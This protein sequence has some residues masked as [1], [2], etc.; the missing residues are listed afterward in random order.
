VV[1]GATRAPVRDRPAEPGTTMRYKLKT[2]AL[3]ALCAATPL[4][5]A[6]CAPSPRSS[7]P[8]EDP[9]APGRLAE[10]TWTPRSSPERI[11]DWALEGCR[12]HQERAKCIENALIS[13]IQPAGVDRVM[14]ALLVVA[15]KDE[16]VQ[17]DGHVFAHGIGIAAYT[18]PETVSDAFGRCTTDFQSGCYHGVIQAFFSDDRTGDGVTAAKLNGLC[19]DYRSAEKRWLDFQC[20]HGMGHGLMAVN[21]HDLLRSLDAC[22]LLTETFE[23]Q[24]CW[25]G[26]FMENVVNATHPHHTATTQV[27]STDQAGSGGHDGHGV[28]KT[29]PAEKVDDHGGAHASG[30]G[31]DHGAAQTFKALDPEEPLYPCTVVKEH[32]RKQCY[33]MQTSAVLWHN[34][35]DFADAAGQ[36]Q[37]AP[38]D[39]RQTCFQSLGRDA[40]SYADG[41][42]RRAI[43]YCTAAPDEVEPF[44]MVGVVKNVVD[45]TADPNDGL[46]FCKLVPGNSK[47]ACYRAVG[48]QIGLLRA[49]AEGRERDCGRAEAGYVTECRFGAGLGLLRSDE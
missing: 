38:E 40:N 30:G 20:A 26:A 41:E 8:P 48:Q 9:A 13:A 18:T 25:G 3:I 33:L 4:V 47:P 34:E 42:P 37:R 1:A 14:A 16:D 49:A 2:A 28:A 36:C 6:Q 31:H 22:D 10:V 43:A 39:M 23:R 12:G 24:G 32:H 29:A 44:C 45:V 21:A 46:E 27:A 7:A 5:A 19:A 11:A 15:R 17:R 35:G